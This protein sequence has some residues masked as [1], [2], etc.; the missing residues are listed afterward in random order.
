MT[1]NN[2]VKVVGLRMVGGA[3][4]RGLWSP[5]FGQVALD[6]GEVKYCGELDSQGFDKM[7]DWADAQGYDTQEQRENLRHWVE[8]GEGCTFQVMP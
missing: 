3:Y 5:G 1:G 4:K 6:T 2:R 7:C 8:T